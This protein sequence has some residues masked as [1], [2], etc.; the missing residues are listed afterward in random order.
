VLSAA[1]A[2]A[3]PR[4]PAAAAHWWAAA[5]R[6]LP[7]AAS[8]DERLALLVPRATAL[9]AAGELA[10]SRDALRE[11]LALIPAGEAAL[12][13]QVVAFVALIEQLLGHQEE[14]H[15]LLTDALAAQPD[16][17][18]Q[19]AT[20]LRIELAKE[21]YFVADWRGMRG[22]AAGALAAARAL[23]DPQLIT[24]AAGILALAEYH[25]PDVPAARSLLDEAAARLDALTDEQLGGRLDAALFVGWSEQCLARWD[26]VHRHY[27]RAMGVARATG[28]GYLLVPMT[29]GRA[30]A[31][32]W[33]GELAAAAE[34]AEDAIEAARLSANAQSLTWA[35]T[36]RCWVATL[37]GDLDLALRMGGEAWDV[38]AGLGR[39]HWSALTGC[40]LAEAR[41]EAG[42]A[43]GCRTLLLNAAG[44]PDLPLIEPAFKT[45]W[46]EL[47]TRADLATGRF[48]EAAGHAARAGAAA[49]TGLPA[50]VSEALRA[51]AAVRLAAGDVSEAVRAA[52]GAARAAH[53][54][55]NRLDAARAQLLAGTALAAAGRHPDA[56][57]ALT[58]A[59]AAFAA[60][61]ARRLRDEAARALRRLGR[62]VGRPGRRRASRPETGVG[63]LTDREREVA[64]L[65][66]AGETNRRIADRLHLSPKTVETHV[67]NIF[68]KL[69]VRSRAAVAATIARA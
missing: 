19:A 55:G 33:Q 57:I 13:G 62:R 68:T 12:R 29:I 41:L 50:R 65:L 49:A 27:E 26:D 59:E 18:S 2:E 61:G 48:E 64:E 28:Q 56:T 15:A 63:A 20:A 34:L 17:R 11:V 8:R 22:Y 4:A 67:A 60:A 45:R 25:L 3:A 10:E 32:L 1:A 24:A 43:E 39:T 51:R 5:L 47:L 44:G 14:A 58:A 53:S 36:L 30:I 42:D 35:L 52:R 54:A 46:F 38:A 69:H 31:F 16:A 66:A 37:A 7:H 9:G 40:Y 23:D 6:L 21:R